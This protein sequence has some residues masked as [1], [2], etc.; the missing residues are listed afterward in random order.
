MS[1]FAFGLVGILAAVAAGHA[2]PPVAVYVFPAGGQQGTAVPVRV[3][4]LFI[5]QSCDFTLDGK[6]VTPS[7]KLKRG[8]SIWFEGPVIP[9]P[10]SQQAE[11]YPADL[12][13]E[14]KLSKAAPLGP[15]RGRIATSEGI[16]G[17]LIFVV[18]ELPEV[19]EKEIDGDPI[20]IPVSL[21][22]TANGRIF[23]RENVDLWSFTVKKGQ[24]ISALAVSAGINSPLVP[25]LEIINAMGRVFAEEATRPATGCDAS[26][27]F[28]APADGEYRVR[29][30]DPRGKGGPNYVYRLTITAGPVVDRVFP[31]GGQRGQ[32]LN[33]KLVGQA[34][35]AGTL[36]IELPKDQLGE[37]RTGI[38]IN[39]AMS[40][41]IL[42]D[43][44]DAPE[45]GPK[46]LAEAVVVPAVFNGTVEGTPSAWPVKLVKGL[47]YEFALKAR[48]LGSPLCGVI[49]IHD[50]DGVEV[51]RSELATDANTDPVLK[52]TPKAD[53]TFTVRVSER[54]R[55]RSGPEYSYRLKVS[56]AAATGPDFK[57]SFPL[58]IANVPRSGSISLK[59][60]A[61][62]I[63]G[64]NDPIAISLAGLPAG[65]TVGPATIAK[66]QA[67]V[68]IK[69]SAEVLA[70]VQ[71]SSVTILGTGGSLDRKATLQ[72]PGT[73][74]FDHLAVAV[75][76]TALFK[77]TGEYTMT[78]APRGQVYRRNYT[79]ERNGFEGP[80][81]IRMA[82]RQ[83]RHLQ[84]VTAPTV[85]VPAGK[86]EFTFTA[87]LS[88]WMELG[89]TCRVCVMA[90]GIV[91]DP[92][93]TEHAVTYSSAEPNHQ[94][95]VV[96]EPGRLDLELGSS[97]SA[98]PAGTTVKVPF[99]VSRA[100]GLEGS[101]RVE[102]VMPEHWKGVVCKA[103]NV[104]AEH[105]ELVIE[106]SKDHVGP[107]NMPA[108]VRATLMNGNDPMIAEAKLELVR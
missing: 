59:I 15:I 83:A 50:A 45:F 7:Q 54:F 47:N 40:N 97:V 56:A 30:G 107:L 67:E 64:F 102:L 104:T 60:K 76:V 92:D 101:I 88:P 36:T 81:E 87:H 31:L 22:V 66:G 99:K 100:K 78:A 37:Y 105:G 2:N 94:M 28:S 29:I 69:L 43:L 24:S 70:K 14:V 79:I 6:G 68:T 58:E 77:I 23:P 85:I 16:G 19:V 35:P 38:R 9:L 46:P 42:F 10:D 25:K 55:D 63:G 98:A 33:V 61:T 106:F 18:G 65:V 72:L 82:E 5:H 12:L 91:S 74:E 49:A 73:P 20:P 34:V 53:G 3:G 103:V 57:L 80:L 44:D 21:P 26:V 71:T 1:R 93:G 48:K 32:T 108:T 39:G 17:G 86:S 4:G 27:R 62:R 11:D 75:T 52:F 90:I 41:P 13:G 84:G 89:R 95:I 8:P 51:A 96:T